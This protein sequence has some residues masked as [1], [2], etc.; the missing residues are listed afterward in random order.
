MLA[1][2]TAEQEHYC[3]PALIC[4]YRELIYEKARE[5]VKSRKDGELMAYVE[6]LYH[7]KQQR[8]K[9]MRSQKRVLR[10]SQL[11]STI[12]EGNAGCLHQTSQN[13]ATE[14]T[15]PVH[16][17]LCTTEDVS[18]KAFRYLSQ[19]LLASHDVSLEQKS[20]AA[21]TAQASL[22][23]SSH[24]DPKLKTGAPDQQLGIR[25]PMATDQAASLPEH[26]MLDVDA[27]AQCMPGSGRDT[28]KQALVR[29][30]PER[31]PSTSNVPA[32]AS[33]RE[34]TRKT[35]DTSNIN[36]ACPKQVLGESCALQCSGSKPYQQDKD[37]MNGGRKQAAC[38]EKGAKA[39]VITE[40]C[41]TSSVTA[42]LELMKA[43]EASLKCSTLLSTSLSLLL[44]EAHVAILLQWWYMLIHVCCMYCRMC[45]K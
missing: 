29:S 34:D 10:P 13:D 42:I 35:G 5:L 39:V 37:V 27:C 22:H 9:T 15:K 31:A 33:E 38:A 24:Q 16:L 18:Q 14:P 17:L 40:L 12:V 23:P 4:C 20:S 19:M 26:Y 28:G 1:H 45:C 8:G 3:R 21:C 43:T 11:V 36:A 2:G 7:E 32:V 6:E 25:L 41:A 30:D 44:N